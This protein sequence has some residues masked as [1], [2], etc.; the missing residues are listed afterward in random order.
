MVLLS[1]LCFQYIVARVEP[2]PL[3]HNTWDIAKAQQAIDVR[4]GFRTLGIANRS[5]TVPF[6]TLGRAGL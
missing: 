6:R 4:E 3:P 1:A 5:F 2:T